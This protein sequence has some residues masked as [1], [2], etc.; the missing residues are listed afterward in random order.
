MNINQKICDFLATMNDYE[1][2]HFTANVIRTTKIRNVRLLFESIML[3]SFPIIVLMQL[4][5]TKQFHKP[6]CD[7]KKRK[8]RMYK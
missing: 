5:F 1:G 2:L 4:I 7:C 3:V 6:N 8:I